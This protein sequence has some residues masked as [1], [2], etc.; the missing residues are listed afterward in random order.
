MIIKALR[1]ASQARGCGAGS[2]GMKKRTTQAN[3]D[4]GG[5]MEGLGSDATYFHF[6]GHAPALEPK[7]RTG[8]M[9]TAT[10]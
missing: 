3:R 7:P 5:E 8:Q 6:S 10:E 9:I 4:S 1:T 2:L